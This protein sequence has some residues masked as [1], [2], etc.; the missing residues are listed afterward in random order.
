MANKEVKTLTVDNV[1]YDI[2]DAQA[3]NAL[4]GKQDK[5]PSGTTGYFLKKTATGVEWAEGAAPGDNATIKVDATTNKLYAVAVKDSRDTTNATN[6]KSWTGTKEQYDAIATKDNDTIYYVSDDTTKSQFITN[7][8]L[9]AMLNTLYPAG[10]IYIGTQTS[11]PLATLISGSSW[12]L[13]ESGRAL[14]TGN[15]SNGN[16][17]IAA[18][19]PNITGAWND[20][21]AFYN[22]HTASGA[23]QGTG[24]NDGAEAGVRGA[25][26]QAGYTFDASRSSSIYGNSTTVQPPAY[27]VNVW[28][29]IA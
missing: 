3:R 25:S 10:S 27:V 1:T 9:L 20:I 8:D 4:A 7:L 5:L 11:C 17:K 26:K 6:I 2:K 16:N 13:V 28:R 24:V 15:G 21:I 18:G 29:R 14:W 22:T 19:L 23:V 12:E